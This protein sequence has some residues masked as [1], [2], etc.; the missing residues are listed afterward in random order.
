MI[1]ELPQDTIDKAK[2]ISIAA[3]LGSHEREMSKAG[4]NSLEGPCPFCGG[5]DRFWVNKTKNKWGCR[6]CQKGGDAIELTMLLHRLDFREAVIE[7][8]G[9]TLPTATIAPV[10]E[11]IKTGWTDEQRAEMRLFLSDTIDTLRSNGHPE[12]MSYLRGRGITAETAK[13]FNLGFVEAAPLPGTVGRLT[14]PAIVIPWYDL[15]GN[16]VALRYRFLESHTYVDAKEKEHINTKMTAKAG[17]TFYRQLFGLRWLTPIPSPV[18]AAGRWLVLVEGEI[19]AM[20]IQQT[21]SH[22]RIDALSFGSESSHLTANVAELANLYG[23]V[24]VWA[25]RDSVAGEMINQL[26]GAYAVHSPAGSDANDLMRR[27]ELLGFLAATCRAAAIS[28]EELQ[29][30]EWFMEEE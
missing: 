19:N 23:R 7:L 8:T 2:R 4:T 10:V 21:A 15:G 29:R 27:G 11:A 24:I 1:A 30:I 17:S 14:A 20:S 3:L 16:L 5:R 13:T 26:P 9:G 25:D 18:T 22:A 6:Q 12:G 28:D